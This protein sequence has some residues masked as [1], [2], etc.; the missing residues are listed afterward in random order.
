MMAGML[1]MKGKRND[2]NVRVL[3]QI[4][5]GELESS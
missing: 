1:R 5:S 2:A 3:F 4:L